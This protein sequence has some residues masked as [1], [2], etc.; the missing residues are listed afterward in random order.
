MYIYNIQSQHI[1]HNNNK[2][3]TSKHTNIQHKNKNNI[4]SYTHIKDTK[5][6]LSPIRFQHIYIYILHTNTSNDIQNLNQIIQQQKT[7]HNNNNNN[8]THTT[9][10]YIC[11]CVQ[12]QN[13]YKHIPTNNTS[14]YTQ[15]IYGKH[16]QRPITHNIVTT[17]YNHT[18]N[19]HTQKQH[20]HTNKHNTNHKHYQTQR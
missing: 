6:M 12:K 15:Q 11:I 19:R 10:Q 3:S 17:N 5:H 9:Q 8:T 18:E 4:Q 14:T 20:K 2:Q 13:K 16:T 7:K 1:T